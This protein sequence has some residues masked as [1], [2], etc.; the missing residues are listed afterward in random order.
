MSADGNLKLFCPEI[1]VRHANNK[2][3]RPLHESLFFWENKKK[4]KKKNYMYLKTVI[5]YLF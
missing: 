5:S 3:K 1:R 2:S 4:K